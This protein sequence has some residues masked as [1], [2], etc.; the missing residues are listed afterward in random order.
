MAKPLSPGQVLR[1][2]RKGMGWTVRGLARM[3][4]VSPSVVSQLENSKGPP[5]WLDLCLKFWVL[6][7]GTIPPWLW[8]KDPTVQKAARL[9]AERVAQCSQTNTSTQTRR[10][11]PFETFSGKAAVG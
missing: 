4:A 2:W 7:D 8:A 6:S 3:L 10:V 11:A 1:H 9:I 5:P